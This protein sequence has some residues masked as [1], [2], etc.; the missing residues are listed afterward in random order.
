MDRYNK[1]QGAQTKQCDA[2]AHTLH[3]H[4]KVASNWLVDHQER[5]STFEILHYVNGIKCVND[6]I[7]IIIIIIIIIF[8]LI[9]IIIIA[10]GHVNL[11]RNYYYY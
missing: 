4:N 6:R 7:I 9:I 2:H 1:H 10:F 3:T 5:P 11:I 8:I